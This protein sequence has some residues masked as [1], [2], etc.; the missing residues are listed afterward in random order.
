MSAD[1]VDRIRLGWV[2]LA[3]AEPPAADGFRTQPVVE[4]DGDSLLLGLDGAGVPCLLIPADGTGPEETVGVVR[5]R[6]RELAA[7]KGVRDFVVVS[8]SEPSLRDVFDHFLVGVVTA[9]QAAEEKAPGA[10]A[11]EVLARWKSLFQTGPRLFGPSDLAALLAEL[12]VLEAIVERDP[13]RSLAV[14]TGPSESR[15]D[16][17]RKLAAIE[18]KATL[19][20]TAR[21]VTIHGVDQLDPPEGGRLTLAW[22]RFDVVPDGQLSVFAVADRLIAAGAS[23]VELY[24]CLEQA[25]C[26]ASLREEYD[27]V[28]FELRE[29]RFFAVGDD[30][31]RLVAASFPAGVPQ[32]VDDITY[33]V[34]LPADDAA[35]GQVAIGRVLDEMAGLA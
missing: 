8:C 28:R 9:V 17:R 12:L 32:G 31:P 18:V 35:L 4:A 5:I 34:T 2:V 23:A 33:K 27:P 7:A 22:H 29:Q 20:H 25:G 24:G 26:P 21:Q 6:N 1:L 19:S 16:L 3:E 11:V 14:W 10:T 15:H 13:T 30:F